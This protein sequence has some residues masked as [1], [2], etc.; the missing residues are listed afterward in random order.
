MTRE[1]VVRSRWVSVPFPD[2]RFTLMD[3]YNRHHANGAGAG[4]SLKNLAMSLLGRYMTVGQC[5][6]YQ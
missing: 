3:P 5:S 2:K 4:I 1:F 6:E